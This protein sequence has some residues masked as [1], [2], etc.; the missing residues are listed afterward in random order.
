MT[1]PKAKP[2]NT[3]LCILLSVLFHSCPFNPPSSCL[4]GQPGN[5]CRDNTPQL[6]LHTIMQ[7]YFI[8]VYNSSSLAA[9]G[10]GWAARVPLRHP[11]P[12]VQAD[13]DWVK[14]GPRDQGVCARARTHTQ[15]IN[16]KHGVCLCTGRHGVDRACSIITPTNVRRSVLEVTTGHTSGWVS[17]PAKPT[18][19]PTRT[20]PE[21]ATCI[22]IS[23]PQAAK[24]WGIH[25]WC[26]LKKV[27]LDPLK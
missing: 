9:S 25:T 24:W 21:A 17:A 1:S 3:N 22:F 27:C 13:A 18:D 20:K 16:R 4:F 7:L 15:T 19:P 10:V 26:S 6:Y 14:V 23:S 11:L 5:I 12:Q 8:R 2:N